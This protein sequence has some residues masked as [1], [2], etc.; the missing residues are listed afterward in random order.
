MKA[1]FDFEQQRTFGRATVFY[2]GHLLI[3]IFGAGVAGVLAGANSHT[4][5]V[6][7][8]ASFAGQL[9]ALIYS[10]AICISVITQHRLSYTYYATLV[11]V[12]PVSLLFGA[13]GGL[14]I[15]AALTMRPT[16]KE[17]AALDVRAR[18]H[19]TI[20]AGAPGASF[21]QRLSNPK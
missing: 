7:S 20:A 14:I 18:T 5:S 12:L 21:G 15:P 4:V 17:G 3:G 16:F 1:L 13:L 6:H 19:R 2:V 8:A 9:V 11:V 10:S